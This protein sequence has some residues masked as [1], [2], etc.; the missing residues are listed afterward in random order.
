MA[1]QSRCVPFQSFLS[2]ALPAAVISSHSGERAGSPSADLIAAGAVPGSP[3]GSEQ[4]WDQ[5]LRLWEHCG[6]L[7]P[8][9][10]L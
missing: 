9:C 5:V 8:L 1:A 10:L 7:Q 3:S 6:R 2:P 4:W